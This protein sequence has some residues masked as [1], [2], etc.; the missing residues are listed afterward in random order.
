MSF[1]FCDFVAADGRE[2][3]RPG[4]TLAGPATHKTGAAAALLWS[5]SSCLPQLPKLNGNM[6]TGDGA[7]DKSTYSITLFRQQ[8]VQVLPMRQLL[9]FGLRRGIL[10]A[11]PI[12]PVGTSPNQ[13]L[14]HAVCTQRTLC[15]LQNFDDLRPKLGVG[16][17][18]TQR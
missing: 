13:D 15:R 4:T 17:V 10:Y 5:W 1:S 12:Q 8:V 9:G 16:E 7:N 11:R 6:M 3:V 14:R 18:N 2:E